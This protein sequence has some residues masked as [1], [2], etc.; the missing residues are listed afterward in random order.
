MSEIDQ[1]AKRVDST[2]NMMPLQREEE[3]NDDNFQE[4]TTS[5]EKDIAYAIKIPCWYVY[6]PFAHPPFTST[7]PPTH[8]RI[9]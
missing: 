3:M 8:H 4:S 2:E 5:V 1:W 9:S 6:T 7:S